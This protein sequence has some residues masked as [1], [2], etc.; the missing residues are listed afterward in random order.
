VRKTRAKRLLVAAIAVALGAVVLVTAV[1]LLIVPRQAALPPGASALVL[2][3]QP[4][5]PWFLGGF[6]C[7]MGLVT[8]VRVG[9]DGAAMVFARIDIPERIDLIWPSGFSARLVGAR[10][11]LIAPNV[12]ILARE[13]DVI[14]NLAGAAADDGSILVCFDFASKPVVE[15]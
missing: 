10:A 6:G 1:Q 9:R 7:P 12:S 2:P 11:E 3:T 5:K 8:P 15:P 13:G 14:S 4:W